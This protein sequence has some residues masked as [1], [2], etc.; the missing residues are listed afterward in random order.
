MDAIFPDGAG[1]CRDRDQAVSGQHEF[2]SAGK[3]QTELKHEAD[4]ARRFDNSIMDQ[5]ASKKVTVGLCPTEHHMRLS[6]RAGRSE[7]TE[8]RWGPDITTV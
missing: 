6:S 3:E 1:V 5:V 4:E 8:R 2:Q 7:S